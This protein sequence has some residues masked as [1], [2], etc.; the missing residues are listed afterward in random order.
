MN[1]KTHN[2]CIIF[3]HHLQILK[4]TQN[5]MG[6]IEPLITRKPVPGKTKRKTIKKTKPKTNPKKAHIEPVVYRKTAGKKKTA[7]SKSE[8]SKKGWVTRRKNT[9]K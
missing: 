8:A 4:I 7:S 3:N 1:I 6:K 9:K 2:W 5:F